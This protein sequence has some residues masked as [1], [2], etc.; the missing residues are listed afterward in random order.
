MVSKAGL[1]QKLNPPATPTH[2]QSVRPCVTSSVCMSWQKKMAREGGKTIQVT[3][4]TV[5]QCGRAPSAAAPSGSAGRLGAVGAG[6]SRT[7]TQHSTAQPQTHGWEQGGKERRADDG[8]MR[9]LFSCQGCPDPQLFQCPAAHWERGCGGLWQ[10]DGYIKKKLQKKRK[11]E[12]KR[13][14]RFRIEMKK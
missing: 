4:S 1:R 9:W 12:E 8:G 7:D 11:T 14:K 6:R 5:S 13:N 3:Q 2:P 10:G